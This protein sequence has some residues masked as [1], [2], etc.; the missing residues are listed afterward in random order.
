VHACNVL[1]AGPETRQL[2]QFDARNGGVQLSRALTSL[3]GESLPGVRKDWSQI[4]SQ[5]LNI[6]WLPPEHVFLR[7]VQFPRR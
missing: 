1:L 5:R 2:W 4:W 3:P 7:V 6:A